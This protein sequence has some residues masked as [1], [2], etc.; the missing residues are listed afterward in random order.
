MGGAAF[1]VYVVPCAGAEMCLAALGYE[2][3][4][5]LQTARRTNLLKI[6]FSP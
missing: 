6:S 4:R 1:F 2:V 3:Y 5:R